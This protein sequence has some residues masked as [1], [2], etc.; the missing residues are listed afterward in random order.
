MAIA[1]HSFITAAHE[2]RVAI[3]YNPFSGPAENGWPGART[4]TLTEADARELKAQ[5]DRALAEPDELE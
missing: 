5:L 2:L 3:V 1:V 4:V